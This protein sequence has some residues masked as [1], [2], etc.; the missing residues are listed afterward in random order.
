ME[1]VLAS[2]FDD[3]LVA[4]TRDLPVSTFFGNYPRTLTGGGRPP[5]IL[6][7]VDAE[8]FRR[9]LEVVHRAHRVFYA[10]INSA[11]L[12]LH[13]YQPG[14]AEAFLKEV[15][16]LLDLGVDGFVVALPLLIELLHREHPSVPISVSTF[17][18]VRTVNQAEYFRSL[19]AETIVLE[20]ANRDF[21][22][23][24]G[25][26]RHGHRVEVLVNQT[27]L[28]G[29]PFRAHHLTTSSLAAQ[30]GTPCP[31]FEYPI[32]ECGLEYL[33]DPGRLLSSI[34]VR[35]EDLEV[36]E[37]VGVSRFKISGRNKPTDWL[38][39]SA[40]A[41]AAR[42]YPGNLLD[43]LSFVQVRGPRGFLAARAD[44]SPEAAA[45]AEAFAA[46]E[47]LSIDNA[48]IPKGFLRRIAA[49]DCERLS[50]AECGYCGGVAARTMRIRGQP[51]R[52]YTP[53][54]GLRAPAGLLPII[55]SAPDRTTPAASGGPSVAAAVPGR[56]T[57]AG[58]AP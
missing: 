27:C 48:Q 26:V 40:R 8:R 35:P 45:Y 28:S 44:A 9:H 13:E 54:P 53:P 51:L 23:L 56:A 43:I 10:T 52:A 2:N 4:E 7:P 37:E 24:R 25:L 1:I 6:P 14:F 18:R 12:G 3:R 58:S 5:A 55:G 11:D 30:P 19:G 42:S 50:C 38:V 39:R 32:L 49:T 15:G 20:E 34:L 47:G 31:A 17:A 22:L 57:A 46:L 41:Y 36:F 33:R 16:D 29:C 21:A